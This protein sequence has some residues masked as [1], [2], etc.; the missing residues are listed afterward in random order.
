[1]KDKTGS[2]RF[3][4]SGSC[5]GKLSG[6]VVLLYPFKNLAI[7]EFAYPFQGTSKVRDALKIRYKPLLGESAQ[8]IGFIPFITK[9]EKKSSAGCLF[10][11]NDA[12]IAEAEREALGISK[13]CA[14]WPAPMAFAG[15]VGPDG[16]IVWT[17]GDCVMSVWIKNWTP[18]LY[19]TAPGSAKED[20][21]QRAVE[22]IKESGGTCEN[23]FVV[24]SRDVSVDELQAY[25]ARAIKSCPVYAQL[26]LSARGT[27]IQEERERMLDGI[28]RAA[29]AAL[30]SGVI[31]LLLTG[32]LYAWQAS[33]A[34]TARAAAMSVYETAFGDR[35][36]QPVASA[37][38]KLRLAR[39]QGD[40]PV[41]LYG[42][43]TDIYSVYSKIPNSSDI[44]IESLRYGSGGADVI[45]T[46]TGN[47]AIQRF[48]G[49]LEEMG[50]AARTDN[51]QTVPGGNMRFSMNISYADKK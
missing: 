51:I 25:G 48:R 34:P 38:T 10:M 42:T 22:L 3:V 20:E 49:M 50:Y 27:S 29:R 8:N 14:V 23:I 30:F 39:D 16:L 13:D 32:A 46:A 17:N 15:E 45:G 2:Y 26:N 35:S 43:L 4:T 24:D 7:Q 18:A 37:L 40:S 41:T 19:R 33:I 31:G 5:T 11:T 9:H 12:E 28:S 1:M 47:E 36:M 6:A 21:A 44:L